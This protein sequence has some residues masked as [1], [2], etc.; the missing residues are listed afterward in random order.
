MTVPSLSKENFQ[1]VLIKVTDINDAY[2]V[3]LLNKALLLKVESLDSRSSITSEPVRT[4]KPQGLSQTPESGS[5]ILISSQG[6]C[7]LSEV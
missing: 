7:M 6:T 4:A 3:P 1:I 2:F 5:A